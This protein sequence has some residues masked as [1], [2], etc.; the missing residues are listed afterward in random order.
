MGLDSA[1]AQ[2][3]REHKRLELLEDD[4]D[5]FIRRHGIMYDIPEEDEDASD[6]KCSATR[7]LTLL[8]DRWVGRL[9]LSKG[10]RL[11]TSGGVLAN[12]EGCARS[13]R[14][15]GCQCLFVPM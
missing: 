6:E 3:K 15:Q 8:R 11:P 1:R 12:L 5:E 13:C 2:W 9:R 7:E 4:E 14:V 10:S